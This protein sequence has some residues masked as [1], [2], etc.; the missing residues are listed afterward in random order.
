[1]TRDDAGV[2]V[3]PPLIFAVPLMAAVLVHA[4]RPW[5][6]AANKE[7]L[8]LLGAFIGIAAGVS[9]GLGSVLSFR[10]ADTTVLPMG[11]P[12]TAIVERGPYRFT[13]NPMYLAMTLGYIGLS[14]LLNNFWAIAFLP[15]VLLVIDVFVIRKEERYLTAKFGDS[16]QQYRARV[17]RWF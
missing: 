16:Y 11:R 1:M 8:L 6:I 17:R 10:A 13:R 9:I 4:R 2:L 15:A 3:P 14:L 7:T 12:T 5:P